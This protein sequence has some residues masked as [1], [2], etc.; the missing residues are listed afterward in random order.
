M[1]HP[2]IASANAKVRYNELIQEAD[3]YRQIS[4]LK[5]NDSGFFTR[6]LSLIRGMFRPL[7]TKGVRTSKTIA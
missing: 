7:N 1:I 3:H 2:T 6:V 5:T 4:S